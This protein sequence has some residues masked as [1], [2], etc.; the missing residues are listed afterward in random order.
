MTPCRIAAYESEK[1][2]VVIHT[3]EYLGEHA[4]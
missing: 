3:S 1:S 2:R 4:S